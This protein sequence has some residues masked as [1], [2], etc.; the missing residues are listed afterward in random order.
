MKRLFAVALFATTFLAISCQKETSEDEGGG[1]QPVAAVPADFDWKMT[2]DVSATVGMP[3]V[4]GLVPDYAVVRIYSSPVLADEN[5]VAMGVVKA[6]QPTFSTAVTLPAGVRNL[7]VQTT[8]PDGTVSVSMQPVSTALDVAGAVMKSAEAPKIRTSVATRSESSSMPGYPTLSVKTESDFAEGAVIRQTP[9]GNIDLGAS[10]IAKPY[11]AAAEYYIPAG[12]EI[13]GNINLNGKFSP[14]SAPVLY[15]AGKLTLNTSV[16]VGQATLAVLPG[17]EVYI[18]ETKAN[19]Q[20]NAV[21]PAVYVFEG[22]IFTTEQTSFSCKTIV[23]EGTFV[24]NGLFN[25]NNSCEFYN[26]A[27]AA[28][29]AGEVEVTNKAKLYNG[30]KIESADF[31]LNTYAELHNCENGSVTIDGT[32][33]VTNYSVT[34]QK[35]EARMEKLE[36][37]GGGTLY[38]NCYTAADDVIAEGAKFYIASGS[39]LDAG[40]VYF[41][42]NTELYA[43]AGSI[44]SMDEYNAGKS[45]GNVR[46]VSQAQADQPMAVVVIREK[47]VSSRYYGTKFEGLME[48]VYDNAA[49]AKYVIDAGSLINGA[50]MRDK[51]TVVIA[52]SKCNGGKEPVTPDPE[53]E[54]EI[55]EVTGAPYTYCFEDGWPWIGDYDMNDVVVVTSIDRLVNKESG[56][57]SSIRI[58]WELKAA[59]AAHLN[60]FA[61]QLDK[62]SASQVTGVETTN[63]TFGKGAFAGPGLES[64]NEYAVIPLFNT[65]QEILGEGTYINTSKG[66]APVPT[67]KHTTTVTF[68]QPVDAAAVLESAVNA[69]IVV[70]SKS[71]GV[72]SR[73]TEVHMPTYKPTG[74]AVVSGNTFTEAE[75]YKYFVSKG[76]GMKDNYMMWGLMIPGEFRYP[77]ERKDIRTA[78]TY[79]NAWAASGGSV[80]VDWYEDEA[81]GDMLY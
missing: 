80:H 50:V 48:V 79:F 9:A 7:Y 2:R 15:V 54:P 6:S 35:G 36:A 49:D 73:D 4:G 72:F 43:A 63:T 56:K 78:Y 41:N 44:F 20:Q 18:K 53:P 71:S 28:L 19:L 24:V 30:G 60:A 27:E 31:R 76:T 40:T 39:G 52:E 5:I 22:G 47:G 74:F 10:W 26:G 34:Y 13:T 25:V 66:V 58:N 62:V 1:Q 33:Y 69:F 57:V 55:I 11:A 29:Q 17:G 21:N 77:A 59:G 12:A 81:N 42:S 64:G 70:N 8:L 65:A 16:T 14:H 75:P 32:F 67:V 38:V 45:G 51:Q 61:V 46:I 3:S 68:A 23:N 37:R